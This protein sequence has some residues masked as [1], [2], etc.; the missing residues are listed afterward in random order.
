MRSRPAARNS[1]ISGLFHRRIT[2]ELSPRSTDEFNPCE[3]LMATFGALQD[4][5]VLVDGLDQPEGPATLPNGE[6]LLVEMG[7]ARACVTRVDHGGR[8]RLFAKPGGRLTGLAIDGDGCIWA[9]GGTG[10]SLV[11]LSPAGEST[12]TP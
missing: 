2:R 1:L 10:N 7:E 3:P 4:N 12:D 5:R 11:R 9:A 8:R 6:I